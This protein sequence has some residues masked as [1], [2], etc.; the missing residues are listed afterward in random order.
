[1]ASSQYNK[2]G[3]EHAYKV[4]TKDLKA[5]DI[6][7]VVLLTGVEQYLVDWAAEAIKKK[8]VASGM[9]DFDFLRIDEENTPVSEI[10]E[11]AQTFP[12]L[13]ERRVIISK[14]HVLFTETNPKDFTEKDK[15]MLLEYIKEPSQST[16][17]VICVELGDEKE[18]KEKK[19]ASKGKGEGEGKAQKGVLPQAKKLARVYDFG[20]LEYTQLAGFAEKRFKERGVAI[21]QKTLRR[22]VEHCGYFNKESDY[23]IF[24]LYNDIQ[25]VI[26]YSDGKQITDDDITAMMGADVETYIF[27]FLDAV[28]GKKTERAFYLLQ[29]MLTSGTNP[30]QILAILIGQF[31]FI[32]EV[33]EFKDESMNLAQIVDILGAKE[34]RV[35]KAMAFSDKFSMSKLKELLSSLYDI[36]KNEKT[37]LMDAKLGLELLIGKI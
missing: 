27:N 21:D 11:S 5:G 23:H 3:K 16:I 32:L 24:D 17:L 15:E 30:H 8:F 2:K 19:G 25:K 31:E 22:L 35:K 26:D 9:E 6:P 1:M 13:S 28:S 36:D 14:N 4:F 18:S 29:N 12:M 10:I 7:P 20:P 34:F 37:G 33:K